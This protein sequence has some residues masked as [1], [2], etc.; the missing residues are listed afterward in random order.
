M[1]EVNGH[2]IDDTDTTQGLVMTYLSSKKFDLSY[3]IIL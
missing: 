1:I 3:T 2:D